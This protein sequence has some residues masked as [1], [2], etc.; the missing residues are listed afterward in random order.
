MP[1]S[2]T[3]DATPL[4]A[5]LNAAALRT[6]R[7]RA[8]E[9]RFAADEMLFLAGAPSRGLFVILEGSVRVV[10]SRDGRQH[11]IHLEEPGGTLGEVP[12]Y[13][14]GAYP[15]TAIAASE[16]RC[17]VIGRETLATM[18]VDDPQLSWRL[19]EKLAFRVRALVER[20]DALATLDVAA[21][22]AA[23][24]LARTDVSGDRQVA[25]LT[26]TQTELAEELGTVREV[27]V[28]Q[29]GALERDGVMRRLTRGRYE[30]LQIDV[31]REA[32][33]AES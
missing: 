27:V 26:G 11:V 16:T 19:L 22:L 6:L 32:A 10:R 5:G 14:G 20:V 30:I 8:I 25:T 18:M 3:V 15:A 7:S 1:E 13:C 29:L 21:R 33:G 17:A 24:I 4:F 2:L 23:H 31:L 9:R 12:L 28:R